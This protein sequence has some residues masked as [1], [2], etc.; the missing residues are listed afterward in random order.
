MVV[1][2][3]SPAQVNRPRPRVA[4]FSPLPQSTGH[5]AGFGGGFQSRSRMSQRT[6][7]PFPITQPMLPDGDS[8]KVAAKAGDAVAATSTHEAAIATG[9]NRC[10]RLSRM[11]ATVHR[12]AGAERNI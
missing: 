11:P 8:K 9:M 3:V 4:T 5:P 6:P 2:T 7:E 10:V 12:R 1:K